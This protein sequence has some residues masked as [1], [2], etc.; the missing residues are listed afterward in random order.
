MRYAVLS[1]AL[2]ISQLETEI[3]RCG[4]RNIRVTS[5]QIFCDLEPDAVAKLQT[6]GCTVSKIAGVKA[7]TMPVISP[8]VPI[9]GIPTYTPEELSFVTGL[10]ELRHVSEP[11]LYGE[12]MNLAIIDTGIRET[13]VKVNNRVIYRKNYTADPMR[14]GFDHGTGVVSI[15]LA[16]APKCNILNLKVLDDK[17]EGTEEDVAVAIDDCISLKDTNPDIAPTVINL[18]L[19]GPD[20]GNPDNP[21][22]VACRAA[23]DRGIWIF[24]SAGNGGPAPYSITCPACEKYVM[25]VGSCSYEPFRVSD[26]SSRGPTLEGVIKPDGVMFGENLALASSSGDTATVAKSG[27]SFA[28][29]FASAFA[30]LYHEGVFRQARTLQQLVELPPSE[31]YYISAYELVDQYLPLLCVKPPEAP[32]GK[33]T[34]YGYGLPYGPLVAKALQPAPLVDISSMLTPVLSIAVFGMVG[35]MM[36]PMVKALR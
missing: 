17:G 4:G 35:M 10:E 28:T 7:V 23:I 6:I 3:K 18:S 8:P 14:D 29:P 36:A 20:N 22:R 13:H 11:P 12:G 2:T 33:D 26:F 15:A 30:I 32:H 21:L 9:A 19:G 5:A 24:A 34:E 16:V 25:A 31:L 27:T 1:R